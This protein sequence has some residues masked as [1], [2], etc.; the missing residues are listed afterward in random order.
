MKIKPEIN[1]PYDSATLLLGIYPEK[2][3]IQKDTCTPVFTE[4]LFTI[5]RGQ[6][7]PRCSLTDDWIKRLWCIHTVDYHSAI[8]RSEF[9]SVGSEVDESRV[10]YAE[11]SKRYY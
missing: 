3:I 9:G 2:T 5:V 4:V 10:C 6:K 8:K 11:Q 7:K 1:P